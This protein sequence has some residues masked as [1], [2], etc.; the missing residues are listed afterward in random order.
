MESN[1]GTVEK[2]VI[3]FR[4]INSV[5]S[6]SAH[7]ISLLTGYNV[8]PEAKAIL[9]RSNRVDLVERRNA[10]VAQGWTKFDDTR[11]PYGVEEIRRERDLYRRPT[12]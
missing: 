8:A 12:V 5:T 4:S 10:Y 11:D 2:T 7:I 9:K 3:L 6:S 1:V